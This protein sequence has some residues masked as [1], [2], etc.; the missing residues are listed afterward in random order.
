MEGVPNAGGGKG[1]SRDPL[2]YALNRMEAERDKPPP[3][4][5]YPAARQE[6]LDGIASLR[7]RLE[8]K[9]A[10]IQRLLDSGMGL[11]RGDAI[12]EN[13]RLREILKRVGI[14]DIDIND[15]LRRIA[16]KA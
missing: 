8:E 7:T 4:V 5:G 14:S 10:E 16:G 9:D 1:M 2:E 3:T 12:E 6:L 15:E 11:G 13:A